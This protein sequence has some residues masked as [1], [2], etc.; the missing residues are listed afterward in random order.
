MSPPSCPV[1]QRL[2]RPDRSSPDLHD[3]LCNIF[4]GKPYIQCVPNLQHDDLVWFI[5]YLDKVRRRV[6]LPH[7]PL[8]L[9]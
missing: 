6:V 1:L 7:S 4:Y 3:Q 2:P 9:A 5:D 8:E